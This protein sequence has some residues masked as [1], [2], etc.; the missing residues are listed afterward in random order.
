M[1]T[2]TNLNYE[3]LIWL[4]KMLKIEN[5]KDL[6]NQEIKLRQEFQANYNF[7]S[8][9]M[10]KD[11]KKHE[12]QIRK[13][14]SKLTYDDVPFLNQSSF[15]NVGNNNYGYIR[16]CDSKIYQESQNDLSKL[17]LFFQDERNI[18]GYEGNYNTLN[19]IKVAI[20][21]HLR[22]NPNLKKSDLWKDAKLKKKLIMSYIHE[23]VEEL[24][25]IKMQVPNCRLSVENQGLRH[26]QNK[27]NTNLTYR[28]NLL[29][30]ALTF[31]SNLPDLENQ[32]FEWASRLLFVPTK[33]RKKLLKEQA[34]NDKL[35][36]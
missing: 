1:K 5:I 3:E 7:S 30:E 31:G 18:L 24:F 12:E 16:M 23:I 4:Q 14:L 25:R 15:K 13:M 10:P 29:I 36:R 2:I 17:D 6:V 34:I 9:R 35:K 20:L 26:L 32:N 28:Q 21:N 19:Y 8:T 33:N 11:F 27:K 22:T